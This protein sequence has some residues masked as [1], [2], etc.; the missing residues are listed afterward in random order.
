MIVADDSFTF[1]EILYWI[2][3]TSELFRDWTF[4]YKIPY[5][6]YLTLIK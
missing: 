3:Y 2:I 1:E 5:K 6:T 4:P